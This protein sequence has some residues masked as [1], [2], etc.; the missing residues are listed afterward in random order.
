MKSKVKRILIVG[1]PGSGKTTIAKLLAKK[2]G[3]EFLSINQV[4]K[5]N[6]LFLGYDKKLKSHIVNLKDLKRILNKTL[7]KQQKG[8]VI[9]GHLG[10]EIKLDVDRVIVFRIDPKILYLRL[11]KR[12][13]NKEKIRQNLEAELIDYCTQKSLFYYK[14]KVVELDVSNKTELQILKDIFKIL[15]NKKIKQNIN[16]SHY[17]LDENF[18]KVFL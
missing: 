1:T 11:K 4:V 18:S 10:C 6:R 2:L 14:N 12:K 7:K 15:E 5:L 13:Y 16:W 9:E 8:I 3:F 17:L